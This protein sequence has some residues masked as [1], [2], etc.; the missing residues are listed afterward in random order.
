MV[1]SVINT[2]EVKQL[3]RRVAGTISRAGIRG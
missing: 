2:P 3:M 1:E